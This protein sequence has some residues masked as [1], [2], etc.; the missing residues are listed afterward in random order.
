LKK[1]IELTSQH[2]T[3]D[4]LDSQRD[5]LM[6]LLKKSIKKGGPRECVLAAEGINHSLSITISYSIWFSD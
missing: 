3:A 5:D 6:D 1:L 4:V 2:F